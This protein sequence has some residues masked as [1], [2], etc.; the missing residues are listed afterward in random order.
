MTDNEKMFARFESTGEGLIIDSQNDLPDWESII[1][2]ERSRQEDNKAN[3]VK[4]ED[5]QYTVGGD[6]ID[7]V[8]PVVR[9]LAYAEKNADADDLRLKK[10][11]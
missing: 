5:D 8:I 3:G 7:E 1:R 4:R 11:L 9:H 10:I 2:E 6:E